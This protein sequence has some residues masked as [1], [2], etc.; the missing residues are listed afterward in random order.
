MH[1]FSH[2]I[3]RLRARGNT[4]GN[5]RVACLESPEARYQPTDR[6]SRRDIDVKLR[7]VRR[8]FQLLARHVDLIENVAHLRREPLTNVRQSTRP[9]PCLEQRDAQPIF[10]VP[11]LLTDR[12]RG[13]SQFFGRCS[14]RSMSS[15]RFKGA[16]RVERREATRHCRFSTMIGKK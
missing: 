10:K 13:H 1:V 6:K 15:N 7:E 8:A 3:D 11:H 4:Y 9:S 12:G 2:D 16:K 14:K 5:I